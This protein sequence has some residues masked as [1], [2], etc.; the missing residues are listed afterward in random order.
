MSES[1][2]D[3]Y[4]VKIVKP[5]ISELRKSGMLEKFFFIKYEDSDTHIRL[6]ICLKS[7]DEVW[8][9]RYMIA[10]KLSNKEI[11]R[12]S[13]EEYDREIERYG[14]H[15][16]ESIENIFYEDSL[17]FLDNN[18]DDYND[19][20]NDEL[21]AVA[22]RVNTIMDSFAYAWEEKFD[23]FERL[24]YDIGY[25]GKKENRVSGDLIFREL[26]KDLIRSLHLNSEEDSK[27]SIHAKILKEN[28]SPTAF[29][30]LMRS[31]VHMTVNRYLA[32]FDRTKEYMIYYLL[33]KGYT[34]LIK[35][36]NYVV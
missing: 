15:N 8:K 35:I 33:K 28:N 19:E 2:F 10:E 11:L 17:Y 21:K 26:G 34:S 6:R 27:F 32:K 14:E 18:N 5:I 1:N 3:T 20:L 30:N 25:F 9:C 22:I 16:I 13:I 23:F 7:L 36:N 12:L 29:E 4:L 24:I 31:I